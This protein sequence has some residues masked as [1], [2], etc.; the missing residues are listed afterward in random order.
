M[1]NT[2]NSSPS[3]ISFFCGAGGLDEGFCQADFDT[4]LAYDIE[5]HCVDTLKHNHSEAEAKRED[6]SD[7]DMTAKRVIDD[8]KEVS[9]L[10]PV[11]ILGGPPCQSFS[12]S[13]VY[14]TDDDPRDTLPGHYGRLL[15]GLNDAFDLDF[16]VFENVPGLKDD[17]HID[18]YRAFKEDAREA[19]FLVEDG[20][21][22]AVDFGVPQHRNRIFVVGLNRERYDRK[23]SFP[24]PPD[25]RVRKV[26]DA[27]GDLDEPVYFSRSLTPEDIENKTGHPNHWCMRPRSKKFDPEND[28]LEPGNNKGRSFRTLEWRKP[29]L[30]VAY[31][32][33]EVHV[34]PECHRRLSIFE[35]MQL[36]C[37]PDSYELIGNMSQQIDMISDA[38]SPPVAKALAEAIREQVDLQTEP[39]LYLTA[40]E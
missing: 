5:Q 10:P 34:H 27:I 31:G 23:F 8:W 7:P 20:E 40:A 25:T 2:T 21:L 11:G 3:L 37:F 17:Q 13:N 15:K 26:E 1:N 22:D 32:H 4:Q 9:D 6:L 18:L 12:R 38:V 24:E 19:G 30:T 16:F 14:K 28:F 33:R 29:S 36:Q 35:A 39:R